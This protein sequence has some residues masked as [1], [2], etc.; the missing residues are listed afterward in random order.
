MPDRPVPLLGSISLN[1]VQRIEHALTPGLFLHADRR[2]C[3]RVA[4]AHEPLVSPG[5]HWRHTVRRFSSGR[6]QSPSQQ[7]AANGEEVTFSADISKALDLQKVIISRST[8]LRVAG[9]LT[10]FDT[11]STSPKARHF[12]R[13]RR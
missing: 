6:S 9:M 8:P 4:T 3:G 5:S 2:T 1:S 12:R 10:S 11:I 7:A 13:P